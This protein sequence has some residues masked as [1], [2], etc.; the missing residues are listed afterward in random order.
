MFDVCPICGATTR[1]R[2]LDDWRE[3]VN[4]GEPVPIVGCGNP[5]H[6]H[7][8]GLGSGGPA[9]LEAAVAV[10]AEEVQETAAR[11]AYL[12]PIAKGGQP[13]PVVSCD[14]WCGAPL[15][16]ETEEELRLAVTHWRSHAWL[17][18]CSHAR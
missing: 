15:E 4:R 18:G 16:P 11:E 3:R 9:I 7:G 2:L 1:V 6:Y 17:S 8:V 12:R 5:W 14:E 10:E 13:R